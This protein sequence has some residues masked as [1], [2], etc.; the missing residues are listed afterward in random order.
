MECS[1]KRLEPEEVGRRSGGNGGVF[2]LPGNGRCIVGSTGD[3]PLSDVEGLS[4]HVSS[5]RKSAYSTADLWG[6]V[7][8]LFVPGRR[9][10][11]DVGAPLPKVLPKSRGLVAGL[12]DARVEVRLSSSFGHELLKAYFFQT[13][14]I[15]LDVLTQIF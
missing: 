9:R 2:G 10:E 14:C 4:G 15:T 7:D 12:A 3:G 1:M 6:P 8:A 13:V 11:G 5:C